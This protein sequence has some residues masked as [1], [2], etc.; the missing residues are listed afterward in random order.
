MPIDLDAS[1]EAQQTVFDTSNGFTEQQPDYFRTDLRVTFKRF[2]PS[3]TSTFG[4]DI[5]NVTNQQNLA[6][7]TYDFLQDEVVEKFQLGL[8][9]LI[10]YRI[11]F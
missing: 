8:I 11:E 10:S 6:F 2:R 4:I 3:Y 7:R 5:Q 1:R 9:P